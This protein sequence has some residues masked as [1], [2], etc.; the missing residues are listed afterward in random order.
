ML[1]RTMEV[2]FS[3][4]DPRG[5]VK[6]GVI[7]DGLQN[8]AELDAGG[9]D[10][11]VAQLLPQNLTWVLRRYRVRFGAIP[12]GNGPLNVATWHEPSRNIFS[13]RM[14]TVADAEG[15]P[16][17]KVWTQWVLLDVER[18]RPVRL[19]RHA[20]A[21]FYE[22]VRPVDDHLTEWFEP[23]EGDAARTV[24]F[25]A[26]WQDLDVNGHVN[27]VVYLLWALESAPEEVVES[28]SCLE[29]DAEFLLSAK[30]EAIGVRVWDLKGGDGFVRFGHSIRSES[31]E[32]CVRAVTA[33][34]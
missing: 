10:M 26:Y 13:D 33:W 14:F 2:P 25:R 3:G 11:S 17:G 31:G 27:H 9:M 30:R 29:I 34:R 1:E 20:S 18:M 6:L 7:L 15:R 32:E 4:L 22:Q 24:P 21:R 28:C 12:Q 16:L 19:D 8:M 23:F 5:R